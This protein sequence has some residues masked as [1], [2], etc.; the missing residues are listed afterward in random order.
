[1]PSGE[2]CIL[3][4]DFNARVGSRESD[5]Q[6]TGVKGPHGYGV[7]NGAGEGKGSLV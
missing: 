2:V 5:E 6:W 3:L 1:M 4:G 7:A